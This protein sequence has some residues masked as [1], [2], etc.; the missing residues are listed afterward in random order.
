MRD[1]CK[2]QYLTN[3]SVQQR[4]RCK[5]HV[6]SLTFGQEN[7]KQ[8]LNLFCLSLKYITDDTMSTRTESQ[9]TLQE[10]R[11]S[12]IFLPCF[13]CQKISKLLSFFSKYNKVGLNFIFVVVSFSC[14]FALCLHGYPKLK[15]NDSELQM[16]IKC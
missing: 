10:D 3:N 5:V 14:C 2:E 1:L 4:V 12:V 11:T 15:N 7:Y 9:T 8:N 13:P 16:V 6:L